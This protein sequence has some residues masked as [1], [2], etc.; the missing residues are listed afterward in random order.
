[1]RVGGLFGSREDGF[2]KRFAF[3]IGLM[4]VGISMMLWAGWHNL[5]ERRLA[6]QRAQE[7][8]VTLTPA[9][10]GTAQGGSAE[11]SQGP[12][13]NLRGKAA[14]GFALTTLEGRKVSLSG[15]QGA[16]GAGELLGDV[17][18]SVQAGDA[19]V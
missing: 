19:V 13:L 7:N 3:V 15:L 18:C 8:R 17:V 16:A 10:P 1:M 2:V 9:G 12:E 4:I 5:R 11:A 14:P 6:M